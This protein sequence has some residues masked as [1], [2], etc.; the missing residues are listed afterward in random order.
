MPAAFGKFAA[1]WRRLH[2]DWEYRLWGG[3][4]LP[5]LRN[6]DLYDRAAEL[7]PGLDGQL[8]SDIVRYELLYQHGG[9]WVDTDF[10][11]IKPIDGLLTGVDCFAAWVTDQWL[12]NAIMGSVPGHPFIGR[13]IDGLPDSLAAFAGEAP[14]VVSGPQ[15]LTRQWRKDHGGLTVFAK[16]LFYPYLWSELDR[17]AERFAAAYGVHH[18]GNRRRERH[19]PL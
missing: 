9:V 4:D 17:G 19:Q 18:W 7:C 1:G 5:P 11:C 2:P 12:N 16:D 15:Y 8:R 13:L 6:Q 3:G 10:E 14:R